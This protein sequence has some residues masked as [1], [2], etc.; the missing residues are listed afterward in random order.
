MSEPNSLAQ[1][2]T[3]VSATETGQGFAPNGRRGFLAAAAGLISA[4]VGIV[5][6]AIGG[7][8]FFGP[9]L[10]KKTGSSDFINVNIK[11]ADLAADG[12]PQRVP[13]VA[14]KVDAWNRIPNV[15]IGSVWMRKLGD[16]IVAFNTICPHLGCA[17]EHRS[18]QK[19]FFC[20]CHTSTFNLGGDKQNEIPPRGMDTLEVKVIDGNILVKYQ[21]FAAGTHEKIPQ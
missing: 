9:V 21:N 13:I 11:A 12:T 18:A 20:P 19:D 15:P 4:I 16:Q 8:F 1:E 7:L 3:T 14:D 10:K 2:T 17:I 6:V 5:P